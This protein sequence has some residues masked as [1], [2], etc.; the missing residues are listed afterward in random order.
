MKIKLTNNESFTVERGEV[1]VDVMEL[2]NASGKIPQVSG[3]AAASV[4]ID[5]YKLYDFGTLSQSMTIVFN[6][7]AEVT[8]YTKEYI[9]RFVA[10]SGCSI[11]LSNGVLYSGGII[12]TYTSGRTYEIDIVNNCAVVAE[13]Y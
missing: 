8:G 2:K 4:T 5:P 9:I 3:N 10:G 6:T 13:F 12:T 7:S 1:S 11:T